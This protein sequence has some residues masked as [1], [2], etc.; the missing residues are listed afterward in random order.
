MT[1]VALT[2]VTLSL[3]NAEPLVQE[4]SAYFICEG[5][6]HNPS[7]PCERGGFRQ[8]LYPELSAVG[9]VLIGLASTVNLVYIVNIKELKEL[10]KKV[11]ESTS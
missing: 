10:K 11:K 1:V 8:Y 7:S 9:L 5:S 2:Q 3:S 6:G 4:L